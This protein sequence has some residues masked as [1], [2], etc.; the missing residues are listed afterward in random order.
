M[1]K[2]KTSS[3][4]LQPY[5]IAEASTSDTTSRRN[6]AGTIERTD[7]FA[8]IDN[9]MTPFRNQSTVYGPSGSSVDIRDAVMLCQKCYYNFAV[10]RN[11][12]DLMT[13][14]SVTDI[15]FR[16]GSEQSR[17]FFN[18]LCNKIN[19]N[20]L[21]ERFYREY[22][23]S[24]NV[25]IYRFD[26]EIQTSDVKKI[27]QTYAAEMTNKDRSVTALVGPNFDNAHPESLLIE[28]MKIPARYIIL[29]PADI[30]MMGTL[31]FAYGMYFKI[32]TDYEVARLRHPKTEEDIAVFKELPVETQKLIKA[33]TR[34]AAMPIDKDR[35]SVVFYKK[36][37][38]EPFAV[39]MGYP[40][41]EDINFKAEMRKIDMAVA[42]TMQQ[43]ILAVTCGTDPEK[44][45]VNQKN[46]DALKAIFKNESVGRVLIADYTTKVQFVIP[47]VADIL[48]PKKYEVV[49]RDINNGL[50]NIFAGGE[51][52]ANQAQKVEL[53]IARL[54]IA[55]RSFLNNF[56][57]PEIKRISQSLGFKNFPT[58]YYEDIKLKDNTNMARIYARMIELGVLTPEQ[59]FR[60]L[61]SN[62]LPDPDIMEEEQKAYMALRDKGLYTP[63]I[64]G[65]AAKD[66][67]GHPGGKNAP[68]GGTKKVGPIGT[69]ASITEAVAAPKYSLAKVKDNMLIAQQLE[70]QVSKNLKQ[71][72]KVSRMTKLQK[73]VASDIVGIVMAN[74]APGKWLE[75]CRAYC[76]SP[77]D[78]N[79]SR[80][81]EVTQVAAEHQ[82]DNYMAALLVASKVD[83][84]KAV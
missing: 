9:G 62:V 12:I 1:R 39:P 57:I 74:E 37:D 3:A 68:A 21:Q 53:F 29:N 81:S 18:A 27:T 4:A 30:Q 45:G 84:V 79:A 41:L 48:D 36:Q 64:G 58:P 54:D 72:H 66:D 77:M 59:G 8:N 34:I 38:Y 33:G 70:S 24:G 51:K 71:I 75:T 15:F 69:K 67:A 13:E 49:D 20:D 28:K 80:V 2:R 22:F 65:S 42:R 44:G 43:I 17:E 5:M 14:F 73:E 32:L 35:L 61:D 46:L 23:R 25:F 31:N 47:Q 82:L 16:D 60:A 52:F 63:L 83:D 56:L 50:N 11:V 19:L 7:R 26:S 55:R 76:E 10:F 6:A 40:V 78:K